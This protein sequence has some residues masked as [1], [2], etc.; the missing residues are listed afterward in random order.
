MACFLQVAIQAIF[1][2][3]R[4]TKE[5]L[6][7]HN[8]ITSPP[9]FLSPAAAVNGQVSDWQVAINMLPTVPIRVSVHPVNRF[10]KR[11]EEAGW[12]SGLGRWISMQ[13]H[14]VQIPLHLLAGVVLGSPWLNSPVVL[15]NS[16]LV[17]L[18]QI[19][20][21]IKLCLFELFVPV[22]ARPH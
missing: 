9:Y 17:C 5:L 14:R 7:E 12:P 4:K 1:P 19:G 2:V 13:S 6:R 16:Q 22:F 8:R 10:C 15:V 18:R 21:L 20:I 11:T 3:Q